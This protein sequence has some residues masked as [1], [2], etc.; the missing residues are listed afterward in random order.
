MNLMSQSEYARKR[1]RARSLIS[2]YVKHGRIVLVNGKVDPEQADTA[3]GFGNGNGVVK[4]GD[5]ISTKNGDNYWKEKARCQAAE[6]SLKEMDLAQRRQELVEVDLVDYEFSKLVAAVR[7]KL[8]A[9]PSKIAPITFAQKT[10]AAT[11]RLIEQ[12]IHEALNDLG[13]YNAKSGKC[14]PFSIRRPNKRIK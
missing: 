10:V 14:K 13:T 4:N 11:Q 3:L 1:N 5:S 2:R 6:A 7:Q 12:G 9:I 8:L